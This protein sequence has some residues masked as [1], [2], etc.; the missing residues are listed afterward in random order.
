MIYMIIFGVTALVPLGIAI[1]NWTRLL[2]LVKKRQILVGLLIGSYISVIAGQLYMLKPIDGLKSLEQ[3]FTD[4]IVTGFTDRKANKRLPDKILTELSPVFFKSLK[5]ENYNAE[6]LKLVKANIEKIRDLNIRIK[7]LGPASSKEKA[8]RKE[9]LA[10]LKSQA[11]AKSAKLDEYYI[12]QGDNYVL[13]SGLTDSAKDGLK[14]Y[15]KLAGVI[16]KNNSLII[17]GIISGKSLTIAQKEYGMG[18]PWRRKYYGKIVDFFSKV[19]VKVSIYDFNYSETSAYYAGEEPDSYGNYFKEDDDKYFST[20]AQNSGNTIIGYLFDKKIKSPHDDY[21]VQLGYEKLKALKKKA[22]KNKLPLKEGLE[23]NKLKEY[24]VEALANKYYRREGRAAIEQYAIEV[25]TSKASVQFPKYGNVVMPYKEYVGK[26][27]GIA[28]VNALIDAEG[29]VRRTGV[30]YEYN[31]RFYPSLSFASFLMYI[32]FDRTKE[33]LQLDGNYLIVRD[34]TR[35]PLDKN[36]YVRI[37][38]YGWANKSGGSYDDMYSL[39]NVATFY[40]KAKSLFHRYTETVGIPNKLNISKEEDLF[41]NWDKY[42]ATM[43]EMLNILSKGTDKAQLNDFKKR[44]NL[45]KY[46]KQ[47]INARLRG[48][49]VMLAS[50]APSLLDLRPTPFLEKEAG[51]QIHVSVLDNMLQNDFLKELNEW[52]I[53]LIIIFVS[54]ITGIATSGSSM[55]KSVLF[56]L[57]IFL[58]TLTA[59]IV[60]FRYMNVVADIMLPLMSIFLVFLLDTIIHYFAEQKEKGY[61]KGAFG[62]YLSP[63]VIDILINDPSKLALGGQRK[64]ITAFFSDVAGFS[65]ISEKLT[66]DELVSL[67]NIYLTEMCDIVAKYDGTVDKF[68]GDAIIAFWGAPLDEAEH[69]KQAC[70]TTIEMQQHMDVMRARF[71]AEGRDALIYEMKMRVGLNSGPAVIGNMGSKTRMDYTMMGDTVNLAARLEGANKF[72]GTYS[73]ISEM[74]YEMAKDHIDARVLDKIQVVGKKE[75]V[76]VYELMDKKNQVKGAVADGVTQYLKAMELYKQQNFVDAIKEFE[77]V[78]AMIPDDMPSKTY[79]ERCHELKDN[80]PGP[81]WDGRHVLTGKG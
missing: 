39:I 66:P 2:E 15:L 44:H 13:K 75:A 45:S 65:T 20:A 71:K 4:S 72:Y 8:E 61:I 56:S 78:F 47:V 34:K 16:P 63:K 1:F 74:T 79:I 57:I 28:S 31:K 55:S 76:T 62:Q 69:A 11:K 30:L 64:I 59:G 14:S 42:Q 53:F 37:K 41:Q 68:E 36:G 58:L 7:K 21:R 29:P 12:K 22:K 54:V 80:P 26:V 50:T 25:D 6:F 49:L 81:D 40:E 60:L 18:W 35:I 17:Y 67:L 46:E 10:K 51:A 24:L 27:P 33:K 3:D 9:L 5:K 48:K 23:G 77:K 70:F 32:G 38:Y 43:A 19:G 52:Y 73:M